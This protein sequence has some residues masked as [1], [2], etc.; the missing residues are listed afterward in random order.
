MCTQCKN[1]KICIVIKPVIQDLEYYRRHFTV[2]RTYCN[3]MLQGYYMMFD[4][5]YHIITYN[6]HILTVLVGGGW[7]SHVKIWSKRCFL[8]IVLILIHLCNFYFEF[9]AYQVLYLFCIIVDILRHEIYNALAPRIKLDLYFL[10]ECL[11]RFTRIGH[12]TVGLSYTRATN[13]VFLNAFVTSYRTFV[14]SC[15]P[16]YKNNANMV[17]YLLFFWANLYFKICTAL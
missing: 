7:L 5:S 13:T 12:V 14:H 15:W 4:F 8:F 2:I 1:A 16:A 10:C 3:L 9:Y 6:T 11:R 17:S